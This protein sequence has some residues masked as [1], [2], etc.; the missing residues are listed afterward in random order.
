MSTS[1]TP[2][3]TEF[4]CLESGRRS[5]FFVNYIIKFTTQFIY[6]RFVKKIMTE[7]Q[8]SQCQMTFFSITRTP[9]YAMRVRVTSRIF[10]NSQE[11]D[12]KLKSSHVYTMTK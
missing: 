2:N 3:F 11:T 1:K 7:N 8:T 6:T 12:I 5:I 10:T 4:Q 9:M